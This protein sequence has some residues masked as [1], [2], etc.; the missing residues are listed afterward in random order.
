MGR[1]LA[2]TVCSSPRR[3]AGGV[4]LGELAVARHL[5]VLALALRRDGGLVARFESLAM[6]ALAIAPYRQLEQLVLDFLGYLE[7]ERGLSPQ[8]ARGLTPQRSAPVRRL[9]FAG[10]NLDVLSD[11]NTPS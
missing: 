5:S 2:T 11:R 4:V 9:S 8:H 1:P 3:L 6:A 10:H 7:F